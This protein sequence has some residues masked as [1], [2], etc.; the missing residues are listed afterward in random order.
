VL[1]LLHADG[2]LWLD[3]SEAENRLV[4]T[5]QLT[6]LLTHV[7]AD[8]GA[9]LST[10]G[11]L[12]PLEV[13]RPVAVKPGR[14]LD[15]RGAWTAGYTPRRSVVVFME[16][17]GASGR[18]VADGLWSAVMQTASRD[19]PAEGWQMPDGILSLKVCDPSGLL[20][21]ETCPSVVEEI[22]LDGSQPV[23][24]DSLYQMFEINKETG[25]LAT[26]FTPPEMVE[27]RVFMVVPPE[28]LPWAETVGLELPPSRYDH[29]ET[30]ASFEE[31]H[32]TSPLM[33]ADGRGV[34]EIAGS[35][36]G[37][38]FISYRLE[39]GQGLNPLYWNLLGVDVT[40]P[41]TE[42]LL[43]TWDTTTLQDGLYTLRLMVLRSEGRLDEALVQVTLDNTPPQ[44]Q[45][46]YPADGEALDIDEDQWI[47][48]QAQVEE[49]YLTEA[50]FYVDGEPI[51][52]RDTT[53]FWAVWA[54]LPGEH[55]LRV[56]ALDRAGNLGEAEIHFHVNR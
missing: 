24:S 16:G 10:P 35:A 19:L 45:V 21:T 2:S 40:R 14:T 13:G 23:Q 44:V 56:T 30:P 49:D 47:V 18:A 48:F 15:E 7:L 1:Q 25:L 27:R 51:G 53:P 28:A 8:E 38:D 26:V 33:F 52:S 37:E 46:H 43:G 29:Y 39:Y 17:A 11:S 41:V 4:A 31:V 6:Y 54:S 34:M 9:R 32:I 3:L 22:F 5:P 12:D 20:P 50:V 36:A 55:R 42:D